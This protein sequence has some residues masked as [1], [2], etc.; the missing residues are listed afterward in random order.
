MIPLGLLL[1]NQHVH[2]SLFC[3]CNAI[4]CNQEFL[5]KITFD[6]M[7]CVFVSINALNISFVIMLKINM[8]SMNEFFVKWKMRSYV[9]QNF[10]PL[11]SFFDHFIIYSSVQC[12]FLN[13]S[14]VLSYRIECRKWAPPIE[15]KR[16]EHW[17]EIN[18]QLY[19]KADIKTSG[20]CVINSL[21]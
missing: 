4:V 15:L 17:L 12:T 19:L 6:M 7:A 8:F 13:I 5:L 11:P 1:L 2:N 21:Q 16:N 3:C 20:Q 9:C 18:S 10:D 14:F